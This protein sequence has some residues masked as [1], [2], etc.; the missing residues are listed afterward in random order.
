[1]KLT[2]LINPEYV[3][4]DLAVDTLDQA[5]ERIVDAFH[6]DYHFTQSREEILTAIREREQLGGT[7]LESGLALP[8]ARFEGFNDV[9]VGICRPRQPIE[10]PDGTIRLVIVLLTEKSASNLYLQTIAAFARVSQKEELFARICAATSRKELISYFEGV[11]VKKELTV[12]DIMSTSIDS[13][14]PDASVREAADMFYKHNSSYLPVVN[15]QQRLLGELTVHELLRIGIP[16]YAVKIGSLKFLTNFEPFE[17]LLRREDEIRIR[18]VMFPP[19]E[20]LTASSSIIEAALILTKH[21]RRH[22][23]VVDGERLVG[24]LSFMDI[25]NK[26]IRG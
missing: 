8:H 24:V 1:M 7:R 26:V 6:G 12:G 11:E 19:K 5:I 13:I 3:E 2:S 9:L 15:D 18:D 4:P 22:L 17:E 25:L 23:P 16:D 10:T 14:G 20:T 21:K